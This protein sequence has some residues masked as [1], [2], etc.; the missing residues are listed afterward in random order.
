MARKTK[1]EKLAEKAAY[2][3]ELRIEE[4]EFRKTV[5]ALIAGYV[6]R[7]GLADI[8]A[9][10][11]LED[12]GPVVFFRYQM[13]D[14]TLPSIESALSYTSQR[15]EIEY[16]GERITAIEQMQAEIAARKQLAQTAFDKLTDEEKKALKEFHYLVR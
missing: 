3:E 4:E 11:R 6:I 9:H 15:W 8:E 10:V 7:A 16:V 12:S 13:R 2:E 14:Y 1:E 5:P